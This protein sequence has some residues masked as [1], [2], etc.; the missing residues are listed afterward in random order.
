M[1]LQTSADA[2]ACTKLPP[3][4]VQFLREIDGKLTRHEQRVEHLLSE[5]LG[6]PAEARPG[7]GDS[8]KSL[9]DRTLAGL[10]TTGRE[11]SQSDNSWAEARG[12]PAVWKEAAKQQVVKGS[13]NGLDSPKG[14]QAPGRGWAEPRGH[15]SMP[16]CTRGHPNVPQCAAVDI[17]EDIG[18]PRVPQ[19]PEPQVVEA[20]L[21][22]TAMSMLS[23]PSEAEPSIAW[24]IKKKEGKRT[25]HMGHTI[26]KKNK[27]TSGSLGEKK[28]A[29]FTFKSKKSPAESLLGRVI[30]D[31]RF[32]LLIIIFIV[33]NTF[34]LGAQ[35]QWSMNHTGEASVFF[36]VLED[37]F[38]VIFSIELVL[39]GLNERRNFFSTRN[40]SFWWNVFDFVLI[41]TSAS[42]RIMTIGLFSAPNLSFL[43]LFRVLRVFR[44]FRMI[45]IMRLFSDVRIMVAGIIR[46]LQSLAWALLLLSFIMYVVAVCVMQLVNDEFQQIAAGKR[47]GSNIDESALRQYYGDLSRSMF[48]LYLSITGG[49]DWGD[50]IKPLLDI[51]ILLSGF[52]CLYIAFAVFCVLNVITGVFVDNATKLTAKDEENMLQEEIDKR[53]E[54]FIA[55]EL[56]FTSV[57]DGTGLVTLERFH[58]LIDDI[59]AQAAFSKIGISLDVVNVDN[60]FKMLDFDNSGSIDIEEF[61]AGI[62]MYHGSAKRID[63]SRI[64][65]QTRKISKQVDELKKM[66]GAPRHVT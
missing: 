19:P 40:P 10:E 29:L 3:E 52:F 50:A 46:S 44:A 34:C 11:R 6:A 58:D 16:P 23:M 41:L 37:F 17:E 33:G 27:D 22:T 54:W 60:F 57:A 36:E 45:R 62:E 25:E 56:L 59:E 65:H 24:A 43:R 9:H 21:R 31:Q 51:S 15:L 13:Y 49:I 26:F 20:P 53:R 30:E 47:D 5:R 38:T 12:H 42:I 7:R 28:K 8:N 4:L 18:P 63:V 39:R 35:V 55:V 2:D 14:A 1:F 48:T 32:E 61:V 66:Y 64:M